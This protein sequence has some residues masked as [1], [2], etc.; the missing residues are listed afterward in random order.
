MLLVGTIVA[1]GWGHLGVGF[2]LK[3]SS[4]RASWAVRYGEIR[5]VKKSL[6]VL[7]LVMCYSKN[8]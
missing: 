7:D 5:I 2:L 6:L 4:K 3:L 1:S 8:V